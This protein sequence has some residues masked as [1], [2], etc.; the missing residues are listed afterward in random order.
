[1]ASVIF[2]SAQRIIAQ[3]FQWLQSSDQTKTSNVIVDT[4]SAGIDNATSAGEGFLVVPGNNNTSATPSVNITLGGIAYDKVGNRIFI[5]P[6]DIS[7]YNAS[8]PTTTT[9]D[10]LGNFLLTP[11]SSGVINVPMTQ[12][13]LNYLW[14]DYLATID[15]TAYTLNQ[16]TNAKIFY[17]QTDGYL[18][19]ITTTNVAPHAN[20]L[21]LAAID[22][23]GGGAVATSNISQVGRNYYTILPNIVPITTTLTDQSDRTLIY[24]PNSVYTLEAHIKSVGTGPGINPRNPHNTSLA[25]I[26]VSTFDTVQE[27]RILEHGNAIIAGTPGTPYPSTSAMSTSINVVNPGS[28][29]LTVDQLLSSEFAIINGSAFT[30]FDI[31]GAV[32]SNAQIHFPT[33]VGA[34][35]TYNVYWDSIAKA[36]GTTTGDISSDNTKLWIATVTWTVTGAFIISSVTDGTHLVVNSTAGMNTG[37][38]LVQGAATTTISSVTDGTHLVVGSTTGFTAGNALDAS[39]HNSLSSLIDRRRIGS[40]THLMER[41]TNNARPGVGLVAPQ[42]GEFGFNL[43]SFLMEYW[44]GGTWQQPVVV[45]SNTTV[46]TGTVLSF[47]GVSAPS[48]FLL[49]NGSSQLVASFPAL[50]AVIGYIYGGSGANFNLPNMSGVVAAGVGGSLGLSLGGTFGEVNHTLTTAEIP[51]NIPVSDPGHHHEWNVAYAPGAFN[52]G[53]D[54]GSHNGIQGANSALFNGLQASN[55]SSSSTGISVGGSGGAHNNVQPSIGLNYI[56]KI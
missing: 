43:S 29:Y 6:T 49:A 42:S 10:G 34:S 45:S 36:F 55:T 22:M 12:S 20:S 5:S 4:F 25:D 18:V 1:M 21:F 52:Y 16:E 46:P 54:G 8:N 17:K 53:G 9:N 31:F 11:Q 24:N 32:P 15:T 26:G 2:S 7:L 35:G 33:I 3:V 28:D 51:A 30:V 14:I 56:I 19:T 41:W 50:F 39:L 37:D 48:G 13:S 38:T 47:A 23:T 40:T 44:D 27:H